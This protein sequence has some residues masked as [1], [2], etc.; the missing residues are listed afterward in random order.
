[1]L[2]KGLNFKVEDALKN[3]SKQSSTFVQH[4]NNFELDIPRSNITEI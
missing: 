2:N 3:F 1:M 4:L